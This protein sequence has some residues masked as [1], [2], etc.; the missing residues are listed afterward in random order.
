MLVRRSAEQLPKP[1]NRDLPAQSKDDLDL[2]EELRLGGDYA[3]TKER[4]GG[5]DYTHGDVNSHK[6]KGACGFPLARDRSGE[7][8]NRGASK[9]S[10]EEEDDDDG[11]DN[12]NKNFNPASRTVQDSQSVNG[13]AFSNQF[14][15][16][17]RNRQ[18]SPTH[19]LDRVGDL[20]FH[21]PPASSLSPTKAM[22]RKVAT[23]QSR[24][25]QANDTASLL[26][27]LSTQA[28]FLSAGFSQS[29][30]QTQKDARTSAKVEREDGEDHSYDNSL[31][32]TSAASRP[33]PIVIGGS[34]RTN[35]AVGAENSGKKVKPSYASE[36][37]DDDDEEKSQDEDSDD[38]VGKNDDDDDVSDDD[39]D[40]LCARG[41]GD[42]EGNV[43]NNNA[44]SN[45]NNND[46]DDDDD[47]GCKFQFDDEEEWTS[48]APQASNVKLSSQPGWFCFHVLFSFSLLFILLK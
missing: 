11:G 28:G 48:T 20:D 40:Y 5:A 24:I 19:D 15:L 8:R 35:K 9:K 6:G 31:L 17:D 12:F 46:D 22:T 18:S 34:S 21:P 2:E 41:S 39:K 16:F 1:L 13:M 47:E 14:S 27:K 26:Q 37:D 29:Q 32:S 7:N 10:D 38:T 23:L 33:Q 4:G 25:S 44:N 42:V 36:D 3:R 43:N 45:N 30:L